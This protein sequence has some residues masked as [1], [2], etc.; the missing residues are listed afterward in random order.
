[1]K[2]GLVILLM[3]VSSAAMAQRGVFMTVDEFVS[4]SFTAKPDTKTL[5]LS[6]EQKAGAADILGRNPGLRTRY[7]RAGDRTAWIL[8]EIGKE[9][10]ITVGVVVDNH[11]VQS[12]KVLEYREVRG[13]EVRYD[14]FTR[15][16]DGAMLDAEQK[17]T[18][19]IDGITG[20]TLSVRALQKIARLAL[21]F[22]RQLVEEGPACYGNSG[23]PSCG[24]GTNA[25]AS[26]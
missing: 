1:M 13:G 11:Q 24:V 4:D 2:Y 7:Y 17:L 20:A 16:F 10:P 26:R 15:Q 22:H 8:E 12:L 9:L 5:W 21:Y 18:N 23:D 19:P 3:M 25:S 6:G 14:S